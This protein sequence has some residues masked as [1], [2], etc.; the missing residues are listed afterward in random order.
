MVTILIHSCV[1]ADDISSNSNGSYCSDGPYEWIYQNTSTSCYFRYE[2]LKQYTLLLLFDD[3][4][5]RLVIYGHL[6]INGK[7]VDVNWCGLTR[8]IEAGDTYLELENAVDWTIGS[9]I[10][11]SSTSY[12]PTH[13]ETAIIAN[14]SSS[15]TGVTLREPLKYEHNGMYIATFIIILRGSVLLLYSRI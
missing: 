6:D 2:K 14:I 3:M 5:F 11:I 9:E 4:C 10:V 8:T 7:P 13:G 15:G 1:Q 12:D